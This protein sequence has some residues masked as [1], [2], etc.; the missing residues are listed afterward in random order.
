MDVIWLLIGL[1][2]LLIGGEVL[3]RGAVAIAE[4]LGIPPLIVGLTIVALGTSAPELTVA[5][6]AA[7]SGAPGI[8]TG[9]V[10]GSNI[11]NILLV[12]GATAAIQPVRA[13]LKVVNR[14]GML[15][16]VATTFLAGMAITGAIPPLLGVVMIL[17]FAAYT[18]YSYWSE[19]VVARRMAHDT[20]PE[21]AAEEIGT[22]KGVP[23]KLRVSIP[24]FIA[25]C[26]AVI[27]GA[28][29]LVDAAINIARAIGVSDAVIGL[30][31]VAIGTSLPELTISVIAA[32]RGHSDV[33]LGNVIGSNLS[34]ILVILGITSLFGTIPIGGQ[35]AWFDVWVMLVATVVLIPVM[36]SDR[37]ISRLEGAVF[38]TCYVTYIVSL[39]LGIPEA[40]MR[41]A[42][43][44]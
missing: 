3:V 2:L 26:A 14:D 21:L 8:V 36:V 31:M 33:A 19:R 42:G 25:G 32:T 44:G 10:V 39:F 29:F 34:N 35:I 4:R 9:S 38:L 17:C 23:A 12:L 41:S 43:V 30:T 20:V 13:S 24:V 40:I 28:Q 22:Y 27:F 11:A 16:V 6:Q 15:L 7:L 5:I 18:F 1:G 37:S